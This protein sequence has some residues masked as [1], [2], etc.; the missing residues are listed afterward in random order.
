M[1]IN[2]AQFEKL[3]KELD[4]FVHEQPRKYKLRVKLLA[5]LGYAYI[6]GLIIFL[7]GLAGSLIYLGI[8]F[9]LPIS[10][11]FINV[12]V[13]FLLIYLAIVAKWLY[14]NARDR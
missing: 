7:L 10:Y 6:I 14:S 13:N 5:S 12:L 11:V 8:F 2:Q 3:V 1:S 9:R 4:K